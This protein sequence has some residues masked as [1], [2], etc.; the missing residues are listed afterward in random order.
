MATGS[1]IAQHFPWTATVAGR[2]VR[3]RLMVPEDHG[4]VLEFVKGLPEQD[5][6]YMMNDVRNPSGMNRWI[7]GIREGSIITILAEAGG[8]LL[9]YGS[10]RCGRLPW[11]RH[12]GEIRIMMSVGERGKGIGKLL[13]KELFAAAH[14]AGLRRIIARVTS[15]QTPARY[16]FQHLGFHLE[17]LLAD[18]VIDADG[19]THDLIFMSYDVTGFHG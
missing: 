15:T 9:G 5:L 10:L 6:F 4:E 8:K 1:L 12:L 18:C 11:T 13:G 17:A 14:D 16:L 19:R 3:F 2:E 7:E